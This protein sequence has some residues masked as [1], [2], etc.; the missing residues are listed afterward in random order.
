MFWRMRI[1]VGNQPTIWQRPER[2][3]DD[4]GSSYDTPVIRAH[5]YRLATLAFWALSLLCAMMTALAWLHHRSLVGAVALFVFF[6]LC[7]LGSYLLLRRNLKQLK[8]G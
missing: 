3:Q 6:M 1:R 8:W 2:A 4:Y 5:E 7:G